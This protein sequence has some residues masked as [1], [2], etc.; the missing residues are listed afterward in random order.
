[1]NTTNTA[2]AHITSID[3]ER[4]KNAVFFRLKIHRFGNRAKV[5]DGAALTEY[6]RL[7]RE[8]GAVATTAAPAVSDVSGNVTATKTLIRSEA[9]DN[10]NEFLS[11]TKE[12]LVGRFGLA[13]QSKF[14][15]GL[16]LVA[17]G[18]VQQF[19]DELDAANTKL[20]MELIP[21]FSADYQAAID[22]AR[23]LPVNQGGL[24]PLFNAAD[25]ADVEDACSAFSI[26]WNWL[27]LSI[28]ENLP[29]ALREA[30]AEKLERQFSEAADEVKLALREGF[31]TL[32][33]HAAEKLK[34]SADGEKQTFRNSLT[35]NLIA[36]CD[37][38]SARNVMGDAELASLVEKARSVITG[39]DT[40]GK[41]TAD[42]IRKDAT[43]RDN[44]QAQF[45]DIATTLGGMIETE[46]S[47]QF[48]F[49]E[50]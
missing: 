9:L 41:A 26:E 30:A 8:Q 27:S 50:E 11:M 25:Y 40:Q 34:P 33:A 28:P 3:A 47:R 39:I 17:T 21:A 24:G 16:F 14:Q 31:Q 10:I 38:F 1:M 44:V 29:L 32:I 35:E 45:A 19:E 12:R 42:V 20:Q 13:T 48:S 23:D 46:R 15:A 22:R 37:T 4:F 18:L 2:T 6:L 43:V 7:K 49:S 5:T 36:F